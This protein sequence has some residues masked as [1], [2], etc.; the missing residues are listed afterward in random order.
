MFAIMWRMKSTLRLLSLTVLPFMLV[1]FRRYAQPM[2]E[3]K[4]EQQE[5]EADSTPRRVNPF[6]GPRGAELHVGG[7]ENMSFG[8][9]P[10]EPFL[11]TISL[12]VRTGETLTVVGAA[13]PERQRWWT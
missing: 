2:L 10:S 11:E 12:E 8:Y 6:L 3:R 5:V 1:V 13:G 9:T 7:R 4:Y